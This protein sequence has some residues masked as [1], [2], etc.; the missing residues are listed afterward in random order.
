MKKSIVKGVSSLSE[1]PLSYELTPANAADLLLVEE[2]L[3]EAWL[4]DGTARRL[5]GDLAYRSG[6]LEATLAE[7]GVRLVT[8]RAKQHEKGQQV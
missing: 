2:L 3:A 4:G 6:T 1:S 7:R 8:E 5:F